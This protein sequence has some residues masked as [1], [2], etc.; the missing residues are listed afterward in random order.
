MPFPR[1]PISHSPE[2]TVPL[3]IQHLRGGLRLTQHGVV[4]SE[5]R[6]RPGPTHSVFDILAALIPLLA[7]VASDGRI[8]L[9]G[10]AGGAVIAPLRKLGFNRTIDAV[11]L[12]PTGH[13]LFTQY[14]PGWTHSVRFTHADAVDW[15]AAQPPDFDLLIEDLSLPRDGDVFK[16]TISW[17]VLPGLIHQRLRPG[18]VALFNLIPEP[19]GHWPDDLQPMIRSFPS[20]QTVH[21]EDFLNRIWIAGSLLPRPATLGAQLRLSLRK[22][23][24]RQTDRVRIRSGPPNR[25]TN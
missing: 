24:S 11:D 8:G 13:R 15:L 22:L 21:L 19:S 3:S 25:P 2:A 17:T 7:P 16:P 5:L 9:L 14:C 23:A 12:D 4:I 18:G 10:F 1:F 6:L 20:S